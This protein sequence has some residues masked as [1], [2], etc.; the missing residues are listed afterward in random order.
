MKSKKTHLLQLASFFLAGVAV[1]FVG[2]ALWEH[3]A[4]I[5]DSITLAQFLTI[6]LGGGTIYLVGNF[7]LAFSWDRLLKWLGENSVHSK[8]NFLIYGRTQ[9]LKYIPGN[10]FSIPGR[11]ILSHQKGIGHSPLI[12]SATLEIIGLLVASSLISITGIMLTTEQKVWVSVPVILSIFLLALLS[13]VILKKLHKLFFLFQKL[14]VFK[15]ITQGSYFKLLKI[16]S[17]YLFFFLLTGVILWWVIVVIDSPKGNL[18]VSI[19]FSAYATS[20]ILGFITPGAPAGA[21]VREGV[22]ILMLST[23]MGNPK[24]IL[25]VVLMRVVTMIG[26]VLFYVISLS[27]R[28]QPVRKK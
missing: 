16:W 6:S 24:S 20:W 2:K 15:Q 12:G 7:S 22:M 26:D 1:F 18:P 17:S 28:V 21:G 4:A 9:I 23:Y 8:D 5:L 14:T 3:K 13:P 10:F 11:H 19:L 25:V 27:F